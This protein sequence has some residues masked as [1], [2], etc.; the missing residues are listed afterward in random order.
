MPT[1]FIFQ[2]FLGR[3]QI[4]LCST[5]KVFELAIHLL[6]KGSVCWEDLK[7]SSIAQEEMSWFFFQICFS[8]LCGCFSRTC[9][10]IGTSLKKASP[11]L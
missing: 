11:Q 10:E 8:E 5:K 1:H 9:V 2:A 6:L 4:V 3:F 7:Q